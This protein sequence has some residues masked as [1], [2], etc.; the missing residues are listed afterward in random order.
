MKPVLTPPSE[1]HFSRFVLQLA[2]RRLLCDGREVPLRSRAFD[3]LATLARHPGRLVTHDEL[4]EQV[5]AGRVV[6]PGNIA[7]QIAAVR[8]ALGSAL[9]DTVP[10]HGYRLVVEPAAT[11]TAAPPPAAQTESTAADATAW[12]EAARLFG[13][14]DDLAQLRAALQQPGCVTLTGPGGV[15]K[16]ALAQALFAAADGPA[17]WCDLAPLERGEQ[18][19]PAL[20]RALGRAPA[21]PDAPVEVPPELLPSGA[22]LVLDNAEHLATEAARVVGWLC[23]AAPGLHVLVTSQT[24]LRIAG[25]RVERLAPLALPDATQS[26]AQA[27]QAPAMALL[28]ARIHAANA[29]HTLG[30]DAMPLLRSLCAALDGMPL[31]LEM[32]AARVPLLG[33]RGVLD[34]LA[35][36]FAMLRHRQHGIPARQRT[37]SAA[38]EWSHALLAPE[39]QR[40]FRTLGVFS[41]GFSLDL[42]VAVAIGMDMG[43]LAQ[44][45]TEAG[46]AARTEAYWDTADHLATLVERSLVSASRDDPPRYTLLET[47]RHYA[48]RLLA[49]A[50]ELD[51]VRQRHALAVEQLFRAA[52]DL[53]DGPDDVA[54]RVR[55]LA[56]MENARDAIAWALQHDPAQAVR[57][58]TY[59]A[60]RA[61]HTPWRTDALAWLAACA[62]HAD[63]QEPRTRALWWRQRAAYAAQLSDPQAADYTRHAVQACRAVGPAMDYAC[64]QSLFYLARSQTHSG[65][66]LDATLQQMRALID[67]H[68]EWP[69]EPQGLYLTALG[70][71]ALLRGDPQAALVHLEASL[72]LARQARAT[73]AVAMV[74]VHVAGVLE[75]LGRH[76]EALALLAAMPPTADPLSALRCRAEALRILF[77]V[78]Q[79]DAALARAPAVLADARRHRFPQAL[80][81][82]AHGV[83]RSSSGPAARQVARQ[84]AVLARRVLQRHGVGAANPAWRDV[85]QAEARAG[86]PDAADPVVDEAQAE[87]LVAALAPGQ[88]PHAPMA[89]QG[90]ADT[91]PAMAQGGPAR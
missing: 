25:E 33:L 2:E 43:A 78:G 59:V 23:A 57:L 29:R 41:A 53:P 24:P 49:E 66:E 28:V 72:H 38:L 45:M 79:H 37:L 16:T 3:L 89:P 8:R 13:R 27:W 52:F 9:I 34:G 75:Q 40:L 26:D 22:L 55:A 12:P 76:D 32:A 7:A 84:L 81:L 85:E 90:P 36:R 1:I 77:A 15:G 14:A 60:H 69:G 87:A 47:M 46:T 80:A 35:G 48:L 56:K 68:P 50:G 17:W 31:A 64:V 39:E 58:S 74:S 70:Q 6:E 21:P 88:A 86:G 42:A 73:W 54:L 62:P 5:W 4:L 11:G 71:A 44:P 18:V 20:L 19:L 30:A 51:A 91:A 61:S 67:A 82:V 10:G 63:A 83:A 65:P